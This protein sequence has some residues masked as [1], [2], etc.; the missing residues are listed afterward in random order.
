MPAIKPLS[1]GPA[2]CA[3]KMSREDVESCPSGLY[4]PRVDRRL[5]EKLKM[6]VT[7]I[8]DDL[9]AAKIARAG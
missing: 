3:R 7:A 4:R 8:L 2:N 9:F 1:A 5:V 6:S